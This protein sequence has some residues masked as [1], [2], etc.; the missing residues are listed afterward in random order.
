MRAGRAAM[1]RPASRM[2]AWVG[3]AGGCC[4]STAEVGSGGPDRVVQTAPAGCQ[5][6]SVKGAL[7]VAQVVLEALRE[8]EEG[9]L[10]G[11]DD[12]GEAFDRADLLGDGG[13]EE[14]LAVGAGADCRA[15]GEYAAGGDVRY[16]HG[17]RL[18]EVEREAGGAGGRAVE[19]ALGNAVKG[20]GGGRGEENVVK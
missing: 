20:V 16:G 8:E 19:E 18:V 4:R 5:S 11:G 14:G 15:E 17:G 3:V 6:I 13:V 7:K 2:D 9:V 10:V 1:E 12:A